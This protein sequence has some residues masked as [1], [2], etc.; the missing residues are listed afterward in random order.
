MAYEAQEQ[1]S[2]LLAQ[3]QH[4]EL[5]P[6]LG[7][8]E[9]EDKSCTKDLIAVRIIIQMEFVIGLP[10]GKVL[11]KSTSF[12]ECMRLM[13]KVQAWVEELDDGFKLYHD[14]VHGLNVML[15][16]EDA[17]V[18]ID[19]EDIKQRQ[20]WT[21][22]QAALKLA[23]CLNLWEFD[24]RLSDPYKAWSQADKKRL[25]QYLYTQYRQLD[26]KAPTSLT[27]LEGLPYIRPD[28][29]TRFRVFLGSMEG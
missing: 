28:F 19:L 21:Q 17:I 18:G 6:T 2:K 24:M 5:Q 22:C 9:V 26:R 27:S 13:D 4:I 11:A 23:F 20:T 29:Q 12:D 8:D 3:I 25:L 14:D 15:D 1:G 7:S 16:E 10:L